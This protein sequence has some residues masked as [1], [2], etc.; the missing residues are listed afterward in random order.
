MK[1]TTKLIPV[2]LAVSMV[3]LFA[4]CNDDPSD[5]KS[6]NSGSGSNTATGKFALIPDDDN[7]GDYR[8][9][10]E[11]FIAYFIDNAYKK[12]PELAGLDTDDMWFQHAS[13]MND[14]ELY[15]QAVGGGDYWTRASGNV[16]LVYPYEG[17]WEYTESSGNVW[18]VTLSGSKTGSYT[19]TYNGHTY[20]ETGIVG[21][22]T[23]TKKAPVSV[24]ANNIAN[25]ATAKAFVEEIRKSMIY[26]NSS[27]PKRLYTDPSTTVTGTTGSVTVTGQVTS[28]HTTSNGGLW[29]TDTAGSNID[30]AFSNYS[31]VTGLTLTGNGKFYRSYSEVNHG[32]SVRELTIT[33]NLTA[34]QYK[35]SYGG[36]T[37]SGT[38]TIAY[39]AP[40]ATGSSSSTYSATVTFAGGQSFT[41][42]GTQSI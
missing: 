13:W 33:Y 34:C 18:T 30:L 5:N 32:V 35:F 31:N 27:L 2:T 42:T 4:A 26:L 1:I 38:V 39:T 36:T 3:L 23:L 20:T 8:D 24:P 9:D 28:S 17:T 29:Y 6:S 40:K 25:A 41:V 37:Y 11:N 22:Y 7:N 19:M 14:N 21:N 10:N 15:C 16:N 12:F